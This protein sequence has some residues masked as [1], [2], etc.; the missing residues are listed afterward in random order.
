MFSW[1]YVIHSVAFKLLYSTDTSRPWITAVQS[2][3]VFAVLIDES[4]RW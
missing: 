2:V 4:W 3:C 1:R